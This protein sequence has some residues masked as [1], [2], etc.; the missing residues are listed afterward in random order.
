MLLDKFRNLHIS[1]ALVLTVGFTRAAGAGKS[2]RIKT[3]HKRVGP[4]ISNGDSR[5][6]CKPWLDS[7]RGAH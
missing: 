2:L 1:L 4:P 6:G 3:H 5:V 7:T